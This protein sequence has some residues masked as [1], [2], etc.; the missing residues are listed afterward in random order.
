M[1][2]GKRIAELRGALTT[3]HSATVLIP[4]A[5]HYAFS[6]SHHGTPATQQMR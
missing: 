4:R 2:N 5:M 1:A 3:E 6:Y